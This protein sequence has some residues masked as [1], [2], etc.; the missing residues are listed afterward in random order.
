MREKIVR[1]AIERFGRYDMIAGAR[2]ILNRVC[3]GRS[4]ACERERADTAFKRV[5]AFFK[6]VRCRIHDARV[7]I[8]RLSQAKARLCAR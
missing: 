3:D 1:A 4:A 7:D 5:D 2:D 6:Y 8:A